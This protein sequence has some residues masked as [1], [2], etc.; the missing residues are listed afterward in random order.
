MFGDTTLT[1]QAPSPQQ[2]ISVDLDTRF[3]IESVWLNG[4]ELPAEQFSNLE[5][6]L[7]VSPNSSV[8]FPATLRIVYSG[9]PRTPI[10]APWD[11]GVMWEETP[12]GHPWLATAVQGEG[13]D[14]FWP[15][16][17]QPYGEPANTE[18]FI[19][20]PKPLVAASNGVLVA[21]EEKGNDRTFHWQTKSMHNTYGIALNIAPYEKLTKSF[22][23]IYG[24]TYPLTLSLIHI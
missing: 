8:A 14:L 19:T 22:T 6:E 16:I 3:A 11:G 2:E 9:H 24:N 12:D 10:R 4:T 7:I 13:C 1:L 21:T 5:G 17:D 15:C 18:L 23:S 20:V